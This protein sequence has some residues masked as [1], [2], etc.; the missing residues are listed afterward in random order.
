[1]KNQKII[2]D[3]VHGFI[4]IPFELIRN[5]VEHR[6]VQRLRRIRQ[7]G[8][9]DYVY[10][11]AVH[12]RFHHALGAMHLTTEALRVL[13]SKG[14][15][16]SEAEI[17][18]TCA[19]ILLHDIGHGPFSHAL[20]NQIIPLSHEEIGRALMDRINE[21]MDGK[22]ELAIQIFE[23]T[24][25]RPFLH[26]LVSS[27][28]DMDRMDYL[29]RDSFF[30]GVTEGMVGHARLIKMLDVVE[31]QLVLEEKAVFSIEK[32]LHARIFMYWQVYLHK[33]VLSTEVM[34]Q[35]L[36]DQIVKKN[37]ALS[38]EQL[39]IGLKRCLDLGHSEEKDLLLDAFLQLDDSDFWYAMK[40]LR[41]FDDDLIHILAKGLSERQLFKLIL[42]SS[43][44]EC[45]LELKSRLKSVMTPKFDQALL[46]N[47]IV[48][49]S[50]KTTFYKTGS[51]EI[52]ILSKGG[53]LKRLSEVLPLDLDRN[54]ERYYVSYP[55]PNLIENYYFNQ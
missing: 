36:W 48:S 41:R 27:Q 35:R 11:G 45:D 30:T 33:A 49:G 52:L 4:T 38:E 3:P 12:T 32:F 50:E 16:I 46:E 19:A 15:A 39:G 6:Y 17:E 54:E 14:V 37:D 22:L 8:M 1:M 34:L 5:L 53:N 18:A 44:E 21:E 2:N 13:L 25:P 47:L 43:A 51:E 42:R 20:E 29:S 24:Y 26:Q 55:G 40:N 23:G 7:L 31:D 28:L 10:P 9:T